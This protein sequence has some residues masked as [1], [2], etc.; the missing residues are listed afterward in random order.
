VTA[1]NTTVTT[2]R[3]LPLLVTA[4]L[5]GCATM[6]KDFDAATLG[7]IRPNETRK[8]EVLAKLGNPF[9]V[10]VDA[11]DPT[12]TYGYYRYSLFGES[13]TKDLVLRFNPDG[14]VKSYSLNTTFAEEKTRLD[15]ASGAG[16][17][18]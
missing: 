12:W 2:R 4:T 14:T 3:A 9:R 7:W 13:N 5:A 15:P 6:G 11:G 10:G 1:Y 16:H 17:A 8:A 18:E